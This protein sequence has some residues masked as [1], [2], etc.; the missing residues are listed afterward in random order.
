MTKI[1]E[2]ARLAIF[3]NNRTI[4]MRPDQINRIEDYYREIYRKEAKK[5]KA[6]RPYYYMPDP[7]GHVWPEVV[8]GNI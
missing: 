8:G 7:F 4:P 5:Q 2:Y 3:C 6:W 1:E